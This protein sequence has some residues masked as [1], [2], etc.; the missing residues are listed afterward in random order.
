MND[1]A[2]IPI[3][4]S[5]GPVFVTVAIPKFPQSLAGIV[6]RYDAKDTFDTK[7]GMF[8]TTASEVPLGA[9]SVINTKKFLVEGAVLSHNDDPPTPYQ[10]VVTVTQ[11][12]KILHS[13]IP[14]IGG[15]GKL[16]DKNVPFLYRF[17]L[18]TSPANEQT[19]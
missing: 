9:P 5:G 1:L 14:S 12:G 17:Q 19:S 8:V 18:I 6:W 2:I 7:A 11:D 16:A 10:V 15:F 3:S 4:S 13:E